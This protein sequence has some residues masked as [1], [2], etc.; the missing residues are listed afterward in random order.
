MITSDEIKGLRKHSEMTQE[1]MA[2]K[3]GITIR[4]LAGWEAGEHRPSPVMRRK[5]E[6]LQRK[7]KSGD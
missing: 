4:T 3:M 1:A 2:R 7:V 5:L 6:R